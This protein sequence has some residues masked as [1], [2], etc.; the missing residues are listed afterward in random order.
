[1]LNINPANKSNFSTLT[2]RL[3]RAGLFVLLLANPLRHTR[4][5][6]LTFGDAPTPGSTLMTGKLFRLKKLMRTLYHAT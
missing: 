5:I 1:M 2:K 3:Y 6:A 4:E